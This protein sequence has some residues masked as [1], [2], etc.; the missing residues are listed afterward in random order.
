[1]CMGA[2]SSKS[3]GKM[4]EAH[5]MM[6]NSS[7]S[8]SPAPSSSGA[9]TR[10]LIGTRMPA[11]KVVTPEGK[12]APTS[13]PRPKADRRNAYRYSTGRRNNPTLIQ[14]ILDTSPTY[15]AI[16]YLGRRFSPKG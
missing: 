5:S 15:K 13:S 3:D 14:S 16:S 2:S 12:R 4:S 9:P 7:P 6:S 11:E 10:S 1:M 8:S